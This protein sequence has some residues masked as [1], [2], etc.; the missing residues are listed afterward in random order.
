MKNDRMLKIAIDELK[1]EIS[2]LGYHMHNVVSLPK[3]KKSFKSLLDAKMAFSNIDRIMKQEIS[4]LER[5]IRASIGRDTHETFKQRMGSINSPSKLMK[6]NADD[7]LDGSK[8]P[9]TLIKKAIADQI[10]KASGDNVKQQKKS[11]VGNG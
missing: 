8:S 3:D 9:N 11:S 7:F 1:R 5:D 10:K 6:K 2:N 4:V